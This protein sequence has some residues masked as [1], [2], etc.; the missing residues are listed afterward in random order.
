MA[1]FSADCGAIYNPQTAKLLLPSLFL[2]AA[3]VLR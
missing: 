3:M 2:A 1:C